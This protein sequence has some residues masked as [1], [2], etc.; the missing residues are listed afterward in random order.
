[1]TARAQSLRHI[2]NIL[3][4]SGPADALRVARA[5]FEDGQI[6][7]RDVPEVFLALRA[8]SGMFFDSL[9]MRAPGGARFTFSRG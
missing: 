2:R 7:A 8:R 3:D 4:L 6:D 5:A 1:M 9:S